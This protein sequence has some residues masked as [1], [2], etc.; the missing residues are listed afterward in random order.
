[1]NFVIKLLKSDDLVIK[2]VFN[3]IVI[4]ID[5]LVKNI[6]IVSFKEIYEAN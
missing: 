5:K 2:Q 4:I 3:S 1:M 6:I